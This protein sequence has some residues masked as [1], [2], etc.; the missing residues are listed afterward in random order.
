MQATKAFSRR[1]RALSCV[2]KGCPYKLC[3]CL[4]KL[5]HC[6]AQKHGARSLSIWLCCSPFQACQHCTKAAAPWRPTQQTGCCRSASPSLRMP[7]AW[8]LP[9]SSASPLPTGTVEFR[10]VFNSRI[11]GGKRL[12]QARI[13]DLEYSCHHIH[14]YAGAQARCSH[15]RPL[16]GLSQPLCRGTQQKIS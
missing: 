13:W 15:V 8:T 12:Q 2:S 7:L 10:P 14:A 3:S 6:K 9:A 5:E 1:L 16:S 4:C 11:M